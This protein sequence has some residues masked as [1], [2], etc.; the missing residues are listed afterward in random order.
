M[1]RAPFV[2]AAEF[3][4]G[5]A[6][7]EV[8]GKFLYAGGRKLYLK[9]VTYGPF[10]PQASAG[11][12]YDRRMIALDFSRMAAHGINAIR[13]YTIPPR[14]LLDCAQQ[15]GLWVL[16]G[17]PWE[18]HVAFLEDR[19]LPQQIQ[20]RV[21]EGVASCAGHPALLGY[22]IGNEI[23][24]N[25]VRWHG[26]RR[27]VRHLKTLYQTAKAEDPEG[28]VV[29][30]NY[31]ST[32]YL[33]LPFVDFV[34][35]N[36][37]LESPGRFDAYLARLQNI[38]GDK[39]LVLAE[40]GLDS[41]RHGEQKQAETLDWQVRMAF[42]AGCAGVFIFAWTDEWHRGGHD[43]DDWDFGLTRRDRSPKPALSAVRDAFAEAPFR[44]DLPWPRISVV[45]CTYNGV[46]TL[47]ECLAGL[48]QLQ[49]PNFEVIVVN[50]GSLKGVTRIARQYPF[51]LINIPRS[52]LS[53]ARNA[54][55]RAATGEIVAY[56]DDDAYP[57]AHW[58]HYLAHTFLTTD[59]AAVG[60]P[61][62]P[63]AT[64]SLTAACVAQAPGGPAHVLLSD[65][66]AEH[67]PGC[68]MAFRRGV[69]QALGGFD[70]QFWTAGDDVDL[71]WRLREAGY[72][73]GFNPGAMVWHHRRRLIRT[74]WR[75]QAGYGRAE[76]LLERKW[77]QKY[78]AAGQL[79]WK[80]RIY[81]R[82]LASELRWGQPRIYHGIWGRALF[83]SIYEPAPNQIWAMAR[84][85]EWY[86]LIGVLAAS[87]ALGG[88]WPPLYAGWPLL[89]LTILIPLAQ[90]ASVAWRSPL[91]GWRM[92]GGLALLYLAQPLARLCGRLKWG[93]TPWRRR[94]TSGWAMPGWRTVALWS[95]CWRSPDHWLESIEAPMHTAGA[96]VLRGGSFDRWDLEIRDGALGSIRT[97]MV[98]EEHGAGRQLVR[99]RLWPRWL[100]P[101]FLIILVCTALA[102]WAARD[103]AWMAVGFFSWIATACL[104]AT[105]EEWSSTTAA[106]LGALYTIKKTQILHSKALPRIETSVLESLPALNHLHETD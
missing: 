45:V 59:Y 27:M 23:P 92:R 95:E 104:I 14:W 44:T 22:A 3:R 68:N 64:A 70:T 47:P 43:I 75:Q 80:G 79:D 30:V 6:R 66:E 106:L 2:P 76:A 39:P 53:A 50:D 4:E 46:A 87:V 29:Y 7:P 35:A 49:Y 36:V 105:L 91:P 34:C 85:P 103:N 71:C 24:S 15:Q 54:G 48:Q 93:L 11:L 102:L 58:L 84:M 94:R 10:R 62:I 41:R 20:R 89:A 9:G 72:Q 51:R 73:I 56:I 74:Y 100:P 82:G 77:P 55:M 63:P 90:A 40:A 8:R 60:G 81:D 33:E 83:Q 69:L 65:R 26:Y 42:A 52:G 19:K 61:N 1:P 86:L 17:L 28:L 67:I 99:V 32:E 16:V 88:L 37:Y 101:G 12:L 97:R 13:T 25:I 5:R 57:D 96:T 18:Q 78:N 98:I 38:A 31:P 21:R